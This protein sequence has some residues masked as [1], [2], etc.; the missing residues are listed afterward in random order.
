MIMPVEVVDIDKYEDFRDL[1]RVRK[2]SIV[3]KAIYNELRHKA[4]MVVYF[5]ERS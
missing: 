5:R 2:N 4:Q 3:A 1:R